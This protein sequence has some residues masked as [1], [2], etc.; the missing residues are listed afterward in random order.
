[1]AGIRWARGLAFLASRL[2][3]CI[4]VL[5]SCSQSEQSIER[6][7]VSRSSSFACPGRCSVTWIPG[8]AV[9]IGA[10]GL[11]ISEGA[12]GLGSHMSMWLGPP[13]IH[14]KITLF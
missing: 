4:T 1:M 6:S 11:R 8:W 3:V 10:N 14:R 7:R 2:P 13:F 12:D 9:A 5:G